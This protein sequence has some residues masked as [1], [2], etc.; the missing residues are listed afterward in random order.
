MHE[1]SRISCIPWIFDCTIL[2]KCAYSIINCKQ[3]IVFSNKN[4]VI[5]KVYAKLVGYYINSL[6]LC[7]QL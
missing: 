1:Y 4:S 2:Y 6:Y 3:F 7:T 5:L